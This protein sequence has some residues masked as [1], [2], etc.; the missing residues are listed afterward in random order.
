MKTLEE[1]GLWEAR[2]LCFESLPSTQTWTLDHA[3]TLR[4][5]DVVWARN[6]TCGRGRFDRVWQSATDRGLTF[7]AILKPGPGS[8]MAGHATQAAAVAVCAA[9]HDRDIAA[10]LKW[11]NDVLTRNGK[12]AGILATSLPEHQALVLGIGLNVNMT[13]SD[14]PVLPAS[15]PAT[16]MRIEKKRVFPVRDM[17]DSVL[18]H[19]ESVLTRID[20]E[21]AAFVTEFWTKHDALAEQRVTVQSMDGPSLS[22]QYRGIDSEGALR[23]EDD[24]GAVRVFW[25]GDVS[26]IP[27]K[28]RNYAGGCPCRTCRTV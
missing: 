4:H 8:A 17:L 19:L 22:G 6:Q 5:G 10:R 18:A 12:I 27:C 7:S 3:A 15:K 20:T 16:S 11:P 25:S 26:V 28:N 9:L 23:I 21:G 24:T 1:Q 2:R 14:F 13:A